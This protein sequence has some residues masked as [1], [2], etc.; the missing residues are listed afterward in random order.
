MVKQKIPTDTIKRWKSMAE[1]SMGSSI[2]FNVV[3]SALMVLQLFGS[4]DRDRLC[5]GLAVA[6]R[7]E[8]R[9]NNFSAV[10]FEIHRPPTSETPTTLDDQVVDM[11]RHLRSKMNDAM[12]MIP[13]LYSITNVYNIDVSLNKTID[14]LLSGIPMST[15][16]ELSIDGT[17]VSE[18]DGTM[19]YHTSPVYI[20]YLSHT[21]HVFVTTHLRTNDVDPSKIKQFEECGAFSDR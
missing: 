4:T 10:A 9:F 14:V 11:V 8:S 6:F 19:P 18:L 1:A 3:F 20:Q 12:P 13:L 15:K 5:V 21:R 17:R 7:N 2:S 16:T